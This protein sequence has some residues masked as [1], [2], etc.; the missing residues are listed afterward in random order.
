VRADDQT[1]PQSKTG[2]ETQDKNELH[3]IVVTGSRIARPDDERLQPT[4]IISSEFLNL[5]GYTNVI[6]A[7]D[8]LPEFGE[9]ANSLVGGQYSEGVGQSFANLYS[10]GSHR[11]LTL[12]DGLRFV[13]SASPSINGPLGGVGEQV[14]L[15]V[16]PTALI[17]RIEIASIGGAPV[18]GSDAIAGTVNIILKHDYQ[19]A[20]IDAE[21]GISGF[22]DAGEYRV[23]SLAGQNF[24][25]G[26]GNVTLNI[27]LAR[28]DGLMASQRP[29]T[30]EDLVFA[31]PTGPSPYQDVLY[32]NTRFANYAPGSLPLVDDGLLSA[33]PNF[34]IRNSAG[35][36]LAFSGGRLVPYNP[37]TFT[38]N[39]YSAVGGDGFNVANVLPLL[40]PSERIN[41]TT[42][43][44]WQINDEMRLFAQAWYSKTR[45]STV[46]NLATPDS[47]LYGIPAGQPFGNLIIQANNA[48]LSSAD[49]AIIAKNLAAYAVASPTN[50]Q[51]TGHF[52]LARINADIGNVSTA[53]QNTGRFVLGLDGT[54][55]ALDHDVKYDITGSYGE[56]RNTSASSQL[57]FNNL[58]NALN[59]IVGPGGQ[60][61]C[62]PFQSNG[63]PIAN[64]PYLT[65][66]ETCAP[67][68]PFGSGIATP[69][70]YAYVTSVATEESIT[71]Q[72]DFIAS[73]NGALFSLPAG[74]VK[75]AAGYENRRDSA[76]YAAND[77]LAE[78]NGYYGPYGPVSGAYQT[79]EIF[80]ELLLPLLAPQQAVPSM[81]R[82]EIEAA[83]REV[84]HSIAGKATTWTAGLRYEPFSTLQFRGNYTHSIQAPSI[85]DALLPAEPSFTTAAD[86]CDQSQITSGPN[87]AVR[88]ANCAKAGIA[89]PFNSSILYAQVPSINIGNPKL[90]V[91]T[92]DAR[93]VGFVWRPAARAR[94]TIDYL[95]IDIAHVITA[96]DPNE[97][98]DGCY[99]SQSYP[100][101]F[102]GKFTRN[103]AGQITFL[104]TGYANL[105]KYEF[106][107]VQSAFEWSFEVPGSLGEMD[108]RLNE[109]FLNRQN[110]NYGGGALYVDAGA[111]EY[112]KH[113]GV[114]D[115]DWH[116][117]G[118]YALWQSRFIGPAVFNNQVPANATSISGVGTWWVNDVTLGYQINAHL[119][120]QVVVD[121][122][123]D[124]QAPF[125]MPETPTAG[126]DFFAY[127]S[128]LQGRYFKAL[129]SYTF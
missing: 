102:C 38:P 103:S 18:Y 89:Q 61:I 8:E 123:F 107:G 77:V 85:T 70:A 69:A 65:G 86:P 113:K 13:S 119:K 96:L 15:N 7:L 101:A 26:R 44:N 62:S 51:Q 20:Q 54:L 60:I 47:G 91:E 49:Q 1:I 53:D 36:P 40:S 67:F 125:P 76:A 115:V 122:V 110:Y 98:L 17:D 10:L 118:L 73:L 50:P 48:F 100:N 112:S 30:D 109:F 87:P 116:N 24:A 19:G 37:G 14:D 104:Q 83:V 27:E 90:S 39:Y 4:V 81:H 23:R 64:S 9:P 31:P 93:T 42:L 16:I 99:D 22:G 46:G 88:A 29:R 80:A 33:N 12:V 66:S 84:D 79:D 57:N 56:T 82:V 121:N 41:A 97:V 52:Y 72:R 28:A 108:L 68:N 5:R 3:E 92:A 114:I 32:S 129:V 59:A 74:T 11:T 75:A 58:Q 6:D 106:N 111:I 35:Q 2:A 128:G 124:K 55:P 45:D 126:Y 21:G 34:A 127:F 43:G 117:H 25:D 95:Q 63:K 94:V 71:T 120:G 105:A 78:G